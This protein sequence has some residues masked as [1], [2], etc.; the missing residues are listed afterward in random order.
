MTTYPVASLPLKV[1]IEEAKDIVWNEL[2]A[3]KWDLEDI[4]NPTSELV[5]FY[6]F[7]YDSF[8]ETEEEQTKSKN[9]A[10]SS[11][12]E[13]S[14]NAITNML[15]EVVP[16]LAPPEMVKAEFSVGKNV[17][18]NVK[19][20]RFSLEEAKTN[21]QIKIAAH[22]KVPKSNVHIS[23]M[24]LVYVPYWSFALD[25]DEETSVRLKINAVSGEFENGESG[26]PYRGQTRGELLEE[27]IHDLKN[28]KDWSGY[29]ESFA[30]DVV[31]LFQHGKEHPNRRLIILVLIIIAI[32]LLGIGFVKLPTP[33]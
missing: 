1:G 16:E 6:V 12:G 15:D 7:H 22:E 29:L 25:L 10:E 4:P 24:R 21:A 2:E 20:P 3:N 30:R 19:N 17:Q 28:P 9:V 26:I 14:L 18:V 27:T 33:T 11:Q 31:L 32:I 5:P 23:G 8:T 13:S